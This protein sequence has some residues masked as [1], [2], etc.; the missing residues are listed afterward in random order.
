MS[1]TQERSDINVNQRRQY[2]FYLGYIEE[3]HFLNLVFFLTGHCKSSRITRVNWLSRNFYDLGLYICMP[4]CTLSARLIHLLWS[5]AIY[6]NIARGKTSAAR[7]IN[8]FITSLPHYKV[9]Q[10]HLPQLFGL[11]ASCLCS[12]SCKDNVIHSWKTQRLISIHSDHTWAN[13]LQSS[14]GW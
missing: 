4:R 5:A 1:L 11:S 12:M 6:T 10:T 13:W 7:F 2:T 8:S 9:H 3:L 14:F